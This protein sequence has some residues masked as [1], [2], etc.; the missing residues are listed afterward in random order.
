MT[1]APK[2]GGS[3]LFGRDSL[4]LTPMIR[5]CFFI[6]FPFRDAKISINR[7]PDMRMTQFSKQDPFSDLD[8]IRGARASSI[9]KSRT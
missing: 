4:R 5:I 1:L 2:M 9:Q 7:S 3:C 8:K 6:E